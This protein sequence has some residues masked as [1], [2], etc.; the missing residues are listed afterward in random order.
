[1]ATLCSQAGMARLKRRLNNLNSS[2]A[3][4]VDDLGR[5]QSRCNNGLRCVDGSNHTGGNV[6]KFGVIGENNN[7]LTNSQDSAVSRNL[8]RRVVRKT[9]FRINAPDTNK[10]LIDIEAAQRFMN[11]VAMQ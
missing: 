1:M 8:A 11:Q 9:V 7:S 6:A 2:L 3:D 5:G 10:C 4:S